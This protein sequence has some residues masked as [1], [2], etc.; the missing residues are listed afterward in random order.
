MAVYRT[1]SAW[2][3]SPQKMIIASAVGYMVA[4]MLI[5]GT[6]GALL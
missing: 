6:I 5:C 2:W 1:R 4:I 3:R